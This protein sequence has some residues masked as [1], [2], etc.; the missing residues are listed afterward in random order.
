[1]VRDITAL[2][3][4]DQFHKINTI[5]ETTDIKANKTL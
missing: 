2:A 4:L 5:T 3:V 1:M